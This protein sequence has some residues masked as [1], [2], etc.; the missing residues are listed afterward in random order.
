MPPTSPSSSVQ[1]ARE[2]LAVRLR[3]IRLDAGITK[4]EL[5]S[6]CE[7]SEAKSSRIENARTAPSDQDIRSW[8]RA[9]KAEDQAPALVAANR[10]AD[11]MY[12][13]WRRLQR[14]GLKQLQKANLP[15]FE[16]TKHFKVYCSNVV[17][18]FLQT[19]GYATALLRAIAT[20]R[21]LPDDVAD[22]VAARVDRS[23]IIREG[24]HR[25]AVLIEETV[26]RYRL[27]DAGVMAGQLGSLLS[28]M[29]LPAVS[30]GVIPASAERTMWAIESFT[31]FDDE[32]VD[33]EPLSASVKI[34]A[35][36]EVVQYLKAFGEL[37]R[38]AV[39]GADARAL[40]VKAIDALR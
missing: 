8:C 10:Q 1:A 38:H 22:A 17:P 30:L 33:H 27:G 5:A 11:S 21:G 32:R 25:F 3:E 36:D 15:L 37:H 12:I 23:R 28:A 16:R 34:T 20:F 2:A 18:G 14:T 13:Q 31:V 24:D 35:P 4:R 40:I 9:C 7:W 39:Y 19:P 6:R 29:D 26:L